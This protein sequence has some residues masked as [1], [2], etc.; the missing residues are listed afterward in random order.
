MRDWL[1]RFDVGPLL[2]QPGLPWEN[3][4]VE[5]FNGKLCDELLDRE[6]FHTLKEAQVLIQ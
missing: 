6:I 2:I 4:S 1:S 5:S 3:G